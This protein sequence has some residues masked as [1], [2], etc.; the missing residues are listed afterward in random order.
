VRR[1]DLVIVGM[2][3]AGMTAAEFASTLPIK[4]AAVERGRLGGDCL[5]TGCVPSKALL[6]SAKVAHHM[7]GAGAFGITPV[8]PEIDTAAVFA[9]IRHVQERIAATD[10]SP[11]RFRDELGVDLIEGTARLTGP[12]TLDVDG[13]T[14]ETRFVLLATGSRPLI[15]PIAGLAEAGHLDSESIWQIDRAPGSLVILG[16][17][18]IA[19]EMAQGF[20]RLGVPVTVL[21]RAERVLAR[22]EPELA[23]RLLGLLRTEGVDVRL[24]TEAVRVTVEDGLKVVHT[25]GGERFAAHEVVVAAGRQPNVEGLGLE[26]LGVAMTKKGITVDADLRS[27]V[28]SVYAAGDVAGRYL[29]THAAGF[30]GVRAVRNMLFPGQ[31]KGDYGVP[32]CTFTD[33]ELAHAG[34]TARE[35]GERFGAGDVQ[36]HRHELAHSD[37]AR[38][39]GTE[40]GLIH[41]VTH[42]DRVVG[43]HILAASA[44]ELIGELALAIDQEMK[45]A[46]VGSLIHV[47]PTLATEI[48]KV[49]AEAAFDAARRYRF[50]VRSR[51]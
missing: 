30:E 7:R 41:V 4:V 1:Y 3:S 17:G 5:W 19:M 38:A 50:L 40:E 44:G 45:L 22:D 29:F 14:I 13:E 12:T 9:R 35:A 16:G 39:D 18:P 24:G 33:P 48:G 28:A 42:K 51:A 6:A 32:W 11:Q 49:G 46:E 47:Y 27:S 37:R 36:V 31:S 21:E 20:R 25:N 34:L 43:A 10:D 8:E 2:G 23:E 15:P 26:E